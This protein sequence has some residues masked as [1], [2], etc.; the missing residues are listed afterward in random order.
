MPAR[1]AFHDLLIASRATR[2]LNTLLYVFF[3]I[4]FLLI[5]PSTL[6]YCLILGIYYNMKY[7]IVCDYDIKDKPMASAFRAKNLAM[8]LSH[9][10]EVSILTFARYQ[11]IEYKLAENPQIVLYNYS[12]K[13]KSK[14]EAL[15]Y[16]LNQSKPNFIIYRDRI[17]STYSV[18]FKYRKLYKYKIILDLGENHW[19][20]LFNRKWFKVRRNIYKH[21]FLADLV[22][23]I[24]IQ[25]IYFNQADYFFVINPQLKNRIPHSKEVFFLPPIIHP[26]ILKPIEK[27]C[28]NPEHYFAYVGSQDINKDD[29]N[30]L[31]KGFALFLK[32]FPRYFLLMTGR[33]SKAVKSL[34]KFYNI[35]E[36][37]KLIGYLD[38]N[39]LLEMLNKSTANILT[40]KFTY[41]NKYNFPTKI[42]QYI[43]SG[44]LLMNAECGI[45]GRY[46]K[47]NDNSI[48]Y[49]PEDSISLKEALI[50]SI[51]I[52][53]IER[54][55]MIGKLRE[56]FNQEFSAEINMKQLHLKLSG[57]YNEH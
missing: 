8:G 28:L 30:T 52:S 46:L 35:E 41:Q 21:S 16:A 49:T 31:F 32:E 27:V 55:R 57:K 33:P 38:D 18:L 12:K 54:K 43:A 29:L 9:F 48:T 26:A 42:I 36:N 40:K 45:L 44:N 19:G 1:S 17:I 6:I 51:Q 24:K 5:V 15:V 7:L 47:N 25:Y 11:D 23:V 34:I 13:N 37:T 39:N 10:A 4:I 53:D 56:L 14:E 50:K 22:D 20:L 2:A 3:F